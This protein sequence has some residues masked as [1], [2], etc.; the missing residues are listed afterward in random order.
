M[1]SIALE[2]QDSRHPYVSA[3]DVSDP[4]CL[5]PIEIAKHRLAGVTTRSL[6]YQHLFPDDIALYDTDHTASVNLHLGGKQRQRTRKHSTVGSLNIRL[7]FWFRIN[8]IC[9]TICFT[10]HNIIYIVVC[11]I[12]P[13][14]ANV[15]TNKCSCTVYK[16]YSII[17]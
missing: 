6:M 15:N 1:S 7:L 8:F 16:I 3:V 14:D 17:I 11:Y 10:L 9:N 2:V 13:K 12:V 4:S 5:V